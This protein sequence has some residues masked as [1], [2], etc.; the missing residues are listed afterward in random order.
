MLGRR[1]RGFPVVESELRET[2]AKLERLVGEREAILTPI[3]GGHEHLPPGV[4]VL[5]VDYPP[6]L[7]SCVGG[8][9]QATA[10]AV[11]LHRSARVLADAALKLQRDSRTLSALAP[12]PREG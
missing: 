8:M 6:R 10:A 12:N 5:R 3:D 4:E 2:L 9:D 11:R 7:L 1:K